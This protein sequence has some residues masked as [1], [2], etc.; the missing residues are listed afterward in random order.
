MAGG[1]W[2]K[3]LN[4]DLSL[5]TCEAEALDPAIYRDYVGGYG[6][7][8][9][10]L[11]ERMPPGA[12]PLGPDNILGF[13]PGLLT[14]TGVPF[15]GRFMVVARSPLTGGWG[16]ANCGGHF[17]PPLRATGF[18]GVFVR[19][20]SERP[21]Y[22][23][24]DQKEGCIELRDASHLWGLD[25]VETDVQ[26]KQE[27]G[28]DARLVCIGPGGE[29]R[30]LV[31]GIVN[32]GGRLAARSGLGAVM[33]A[34]R[35][36][37]VVVRGSERIPIQDEETLS[38]LNKA[39]RQIFKS[40]PLPV[41]RYL[42]RVIRLVAPLIRRF[43]VEFPTSAPEPLIY[44]YKEYGTCSGTAFASEVGDA[45]VKNWLGS[46]MHDFPL[47]RSS[48]I[49]DDAVTRYSVKKYACQHCPL[50]CGGIVSLDGPRYSVEKTHKPEYETLAGLG[51]LLLND[52]VESIIVMGDVCDRYGLDTISVGGIVGFALECVDKGVLSREEVD[53]LDLRWGNADAMVELVGKI[54][55]REGI[56][57]LLADGVKRAAERIGKGAEEC[58]VHVGGQEIAMHDSRY[59]P[60]LGLAYQVDPTPGRHTVADG[61][62]YNLPSLKAVFD[63]ENL[64]PVE[65]R[66]CQGK[67][68]LFA[69]MNR[70]L[71]V[72]NCAGLCMFSLIVGQPP[73]REWINAATGWDLSLEELLRVGHRVQVLRHAFNLRE[74][75][76][77]GDFS[78]PAR[79]VGV[80]PLAEGPLKGVTL[81]METMVRD[82]R[83]A[84]GY[85]EA[86]GAPTDELLES[87]GLAGIV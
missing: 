40:R 64:T 28:H 26:L 13:T 6:L 9:R 50:G 11:Y 74:G 77:P 44:M 81:D 72:V 78:L 42:T 18:D 35:L 3:I 21:V 33:G 79:A 30:S 41:F 37:A 4:V 49:S 47:S 32:D 86:T 71:Q 10:L 17:G 55:R 58:A 14:G 54:A 70:Y 82:F 61:G 43:N 5:G 75:I 23:L 53:G 65:R 51:T 63:L 36:K 57:D 29:N 80:P 38:R 56:G 27:V 60:M 8:V 67:G 46:G 48:R 62:I 25:S 66:T 68:A 7:G 39:H 69:V 2:G 52:D 22:L 20:V 24:V 87:L 15:S 59:E 73:V 34:K 12:D 83:R 31:A 19:G 85:D 16:D 76:R 84:M 45:P 1:F